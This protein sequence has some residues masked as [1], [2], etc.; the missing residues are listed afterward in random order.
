MKIRLIEREDFDAVVEMS[1][2][3]MET[4]RSELTF[5]ETRCRETLESSV[6]SA[7]PTIYVCEDKDEVIGFVVM[8]F[9]PYQAADGLFAVQEVLYVKPV[10]RGSRAAT[11]LMRQ[12]IEWAGIIG[13]KE[14]VGGNDNAF[15]SDRTAKF[16]GHFGF[17]KV[18]Y[19]MRRRL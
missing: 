4:T 6:A 9:L 14:I 13:C 11:L 15:N 5:S 19:A 17:E 3:N 8:D 7:T 2:H 1:R 10:K 16:L 18:G 12:L